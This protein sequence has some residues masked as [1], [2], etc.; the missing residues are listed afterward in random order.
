MN[1]Y[2]VSAESNM[3]ISKD[4]ADSLDIS[5]IYANY[6]IDG[7]VY[8]DDFG[9]SLDVKSFYQAME[10]GANPT[11]SGINTQEYIDYFRPIL[12]DGKDIIHVC[13]STGLSSQYSS[14][15]EAIKLL[16]EEFTDRKIYP[17]DSRMASSGIGLLVARLSELKKQG[18]PIDDL[19]DWAI[20]NRLSVI[21]YTSN[22]D[23]TYVARGGRVSKTAANLG[24][25]LHIFPIIEVDD[26]GY[27]KVTSKIRSEKK[28]IK[29]ILNNMKANAIG[30]SDYN[31]EV[32]IATADN[33]ELAE[34]L[35]VA[36]T[37]E[38]KEID[39]KV[40]IFNIGPTIGS[41]IGPGSINVFYW[42]KDRMALKKL[43]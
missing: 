14:L 10:E 9:Q 28:Y 21:S 42:G 20:E 7:E 6:E 30:G 40:R 2:V 38:F 36:I 1:D 33:Y 26:E 34:K 15:L 19:Y 27:L 35:K 32:Y 4:F 16:E 43:S 37:E 22:S 39:D 18:M 5:V 23:L 11:T 29:A 12:A 41:H 3:D 25:M 31:G 13:L 24:G 17:V 8:L